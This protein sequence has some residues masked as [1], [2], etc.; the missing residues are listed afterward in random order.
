MYESTINYDVNDKNDVES[1]HIKD[2]EFI[3]QQYKS[4][5]FWIGNNPW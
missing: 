3:T 4:T 5:T 1:I 2:T